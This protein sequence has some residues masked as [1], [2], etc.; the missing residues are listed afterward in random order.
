MGASFSSFSF[1]PPPPPPPPHPPELLGTRFISGSLP[2]HSVRR[3]GKELGPGMRRLWILP[4]LVIPC[5]LAGQKCKDEVRKINA[6]LTVPMVPA[7]A[8]LIK[9]DNMLDACT[10]YERQECIPGLTIGAS[11]GFRTTPFIRV[12]D[13]VRLELLSRPTLLPSTARHH[14]AGCPT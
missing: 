14:G 5:P 13:V 8:L 2:A 7:M 3:L 4:K 10:L 12:V 6:R 11:S 1:P 9:R